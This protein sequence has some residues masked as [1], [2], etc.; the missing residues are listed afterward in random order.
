MA[1]KQQTKKAN[2]PEDIIR[3]LYL[4]EGKPIV[5]EPDLDQQSDEIVASKYGKCDALIPLLRAVL[6]ELVWA[7]LERRRH[8]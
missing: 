3:P 1:S 7:R 5:V 4:S 2:K 8:G 6:K